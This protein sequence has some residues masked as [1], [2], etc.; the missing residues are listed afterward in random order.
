MSDYL[1]EYLGTDWIDF[2]NVEEYIDL[3]EYL[4]DNQ[5]T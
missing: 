4:E 1:E 3:L 2:Y 5:D